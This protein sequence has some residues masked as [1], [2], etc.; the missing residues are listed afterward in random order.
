L[1]SPPHV[2][3]P[4][5]THASDL[6]AYTVQAAPQLEELAEQ[7]LQLS[8]GCA[9][10]AASSSPTPEVGSALS[11]TQAEPKAQRTPKSDS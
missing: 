9:V 2:D 4:T 1:D 8:A 7:R 3:V 6:H 11:A 10:S 5:G